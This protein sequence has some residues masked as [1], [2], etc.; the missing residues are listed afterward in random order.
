MYRTYRKTQQKIL[1]HKEANLKNLLKQSAVCFG[2]KRNAEEYLHESIIPTMH[3]QKSLPRLPIPKLEDTTQRYLMSQK[4]LLTPDKYK[5]TKEITENFLGY[6]GRALHAELVEKDKSMKHTSYISAPWF[7]MYLKYRDSIMLTHNPFVLAS[8]DPNSMDQLTRATKLIYSSLLF[9]N[10]LDDNV[11]EPDVYHLNPKKSDT[12]LF[13]RLS[14]MTPS[15][16]SWY[17]AYLFKAFPLDMSQYARLFNSTRVPKIGKDKLKTVKNN[18]QILVIRNGNIFLF[19]AIKEDGSLVSRDSIHANLL[20][21]KNASNEL[22]S[23]PLP[24]LTSE[25]RDTWAKLREHLEKDGN[26]KALLH[27][28]DGAL[29]GVFLDDKVCSDE[30]DAKEIFLHGDGHSRWFDKSFHL[31]LSSNGKMAINF[32]H[33]WGDG[34]AVVRY[35][36]E[37]CST[38]DKDNF[39]PKENADTVL[40]VQ[41]LDFQLDDT[42]KTAIEKAQDVFNERTKQVDINAQK[43]ELFGKNYLKTK[44]LS[45]DAVMQLAFQMAYYRQHGKHTATYESCATAA[46]KHG[47]TETLRPCTVATVA[48]AEA[49]ESSHQANV[50]EMQE[51]LQDT[52]KMHGQLTKEAAMGQGFDRHLFALRYLAEENGRNIDFFNDE[53]YKNI[54]HIIISTSTVFSPYIQMGGFAPVVAD[55]LGVGYMVT[56]DWL[57][58]NTTS[59]PGSPNGAEFVELVMKSLADIHSVLEGRNFK[60]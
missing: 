27:K 39:Q 24:V 48:C 54:N 6:E 18:R 57:G 3:F 2:T 32:E 4:P 30:V 7:D 8:D 13:K 10:S 16:L 36:N 56:D 20:A 59:Y 51:L 9:K 40:T 49:F 35:L 55:G 53:A 45:P 38:S 29:F 43:T 44:K 47:R 5:T 42:M 50:E 15:Q 12:K 26:N 21:I 37:V 25:K 11:L 19:D 23:H 1:V 33:A 31:A 34:V 41:K 28:L 58:C 14:S 52:S 60:H 17:M 22:V 46:F